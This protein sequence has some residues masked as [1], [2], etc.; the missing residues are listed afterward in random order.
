VPDAS[1]FGEKKLETPV[2]CLAVARQQTIR[3][4]MKISLVEIFQFSEPNIAVHPSPLRTRYQTACPAMR[5]AGT[6]NQE[7][8]QLDV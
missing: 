5:L 4:L 7:H 6:D 8:R 1:R 3:Q 2:Y